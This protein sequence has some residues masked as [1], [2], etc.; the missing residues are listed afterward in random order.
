MQEELGAL[1]VWGAGRFLFVTRRLL[2]H[3][4]QVDT[5]A[6][7]CNKGYDQLYSGQ[8]ISDWEIFL[9]SGRLI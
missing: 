3:G 2:S 5:T 7:V 8:I 9:R 1:G 4:I 6:R